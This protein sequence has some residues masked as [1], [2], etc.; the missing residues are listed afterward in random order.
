MFAI[1]GGIL[2]AVVVL[3]V[4]LAFWP[5]VLS[6]AAGWLAGFVTFVVV[7]FSTNGPMS[8]NA[9]ENLWLAVAF[10]SIVAAWL[11]YEATIRARRHL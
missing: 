7:V 6:L 11:T 4:G 9:N 8:E 2:L 10:V 3:V 5:A 1:A